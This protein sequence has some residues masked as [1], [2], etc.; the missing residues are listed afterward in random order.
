MAQPMKRRVLFS[1]QFQF[2]SPHSHTA[3]ALRHESS[4]SGDECYGTNRLP[5]V[6]I[7]AATVKRQTD[8]S[9]QEKLRS[10]E[11][12]SNDVAVGR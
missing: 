4:I 11:S 8:C 6:S 7:T 9:A 10:D 2:T 5:A 12:L 1:I 3:G